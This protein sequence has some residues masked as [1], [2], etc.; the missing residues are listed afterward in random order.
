LNIEE[1]EIYRRSLPGTLKG[2]FMNVIRREA[3]FFCLTGAST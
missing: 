1:Y 3:V 2:V